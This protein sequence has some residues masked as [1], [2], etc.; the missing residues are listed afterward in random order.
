MKQPDLR[1][2]VCGA[3]PPLA[4]GRR[5]RQG[6]SPGPAA[7]KGGS[8]EPWALSCWAPVKVNQWL[9][10]TSQSCLFLQGNRTNTHAR[11]SSEPFSKIAVFEAC[12]T[13]VIKEGRLGLE[14]Y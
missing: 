7:L 3:V 10:S 8:P 13:Y 1:P 4:T 14:C 5:L 2:I 9:V 11:G 12:K 6:G